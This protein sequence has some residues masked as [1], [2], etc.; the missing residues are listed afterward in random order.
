MDQF[1]PDQPGGSGNPDPGR[2]RSFDEAPARRAG[3]ADLPGLHAEPGLGTPAPHSAEPGLRPGSDSREAGMGAERSARDMGREA[4]R[5]KERARR[6]A[7]TV[8]SE[9]KEGLAAR[10]STLGRA[11]DDA[12]RRL[13]ESDEPGVGDYAGSA[14]R[15]LSRTAEYLRSSDP[16][17]LLRD[18]QGFARRRPEVFIGAAVLAGVLIGRFVRSSGT[19]QG[20][21]MDKPGY[22]RE[23][24]R[25]HDEPG[26]Y[27]ATAQRDRRDTDRMPGGAGG[28]TGG[29]AG[30]ESGGPGVGGRGSP[31]TDPRVGRRGF[32]GDSGGA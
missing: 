23:D 11:L 27:D 31:T 12:S 7:D 5:L 16:G 8:V 17:Q 3:E 32:E 4:S 20:R 26:D 30:P 24:I 6:E 2:I 29:A 14:A 18:L 9:G 10:M 15:Q 13:R 19:G 21:Y 28:A 22:E 25:H 1:K